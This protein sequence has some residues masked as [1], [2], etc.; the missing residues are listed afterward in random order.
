MK[1]LAIAQTKLRGNRTY[2]YRERPKGY[3]KSIKSSSL[4]EKS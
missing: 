4:V 1:K 2:D 3:Y